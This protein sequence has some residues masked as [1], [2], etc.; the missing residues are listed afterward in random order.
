MISQRRRA[1]EWWKVPAIHRMASRTG[2]PSAQFARHGNRI[3]IHARSV[4]SERIRKFVA[5][6]SSSPAIMP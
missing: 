4:E 6:G 3:A 1:S 5:L 2:I